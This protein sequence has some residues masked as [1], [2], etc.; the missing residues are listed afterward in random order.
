MLG[1]SAETG[2]QY[3]FYVVH[4][5]PPKDPHQHASEIQFVAFATTRD[6]YE[7]TL[8]PH[9]YMEDG[10]M[11]LRNRT[12]VLGWPARFFGIG[13]D[14]PNEPQLYDADIVDIYTTLD[15]NWF[16]CLTL[17]LRTRYLYEKIDSDPEGPLLSENVSGARGGSSAGLGLTIAY[18]TRDN[19][20]APHE[21]Q[22]VRYGNLFYSE[23]MGGDF[24]YQV[25][26]LDLRAYIPVTHG[27]SFACAA[28]LRAA[29]GDTPFRELSSPDGRGVLRAIERGRYRDRYLFWVQGEYRLSFSDTWSTAFFVDA[30]QVAPAV[31]ALKHDAFKY[32]IGT[33]L[34]YALNPTEQ[35]KVRMD[36]AWVDNA[37]GIILYILEAF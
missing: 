3:G 32:S 37:P 5:L 18:D 12:A 4:F 1:L 16:D 34:R 14:S 22:L 13:N 19:P 20:N 21:G 24:T 8:K 33:G 31:S 2:W 10:R 30:A 25:H 15:R 27:S 35:F 26:E 11:E 6:Q 36:V 17:G 9:I 7:I 28:G 23:Y 29:E